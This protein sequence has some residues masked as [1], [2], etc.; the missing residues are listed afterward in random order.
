MNRILQG[1]LSVY[2][3]EE[4]ISTLMGLLY[5]QISAP[6]C[7][8]ANE[9]RQVRENIPNDLDFLSYLM[10]CQTTMNPE[11]GRCYGLDVNAPWR[12]DQDQERFEKAAK[13]LHVEEL[14][15]IMA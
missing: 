2:G 13:F 15:R 12:N 14:G 1:M 10:E 7:K 4:T 9:I 8:Q 5:E 11:T 3:I 6:D